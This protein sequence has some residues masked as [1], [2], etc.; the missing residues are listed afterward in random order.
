MFW[1]LLN[2]LKW[3][4]LD[5]ILDNIGKNNNFYLIDFKHQM[6]E[7]MTKFSNKFELKTKKD[8]INLACKNPKNLYIIFGSLY[9]IKEFLNV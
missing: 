1:L 2:F 7:D 5:L 4:N 3:K 9:M 8:I 6:L